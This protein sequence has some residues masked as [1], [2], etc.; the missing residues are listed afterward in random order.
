M[1]RE[2]SLELK[3]T[4]LW[5]HLCYGKSFKFISK[6]YGVSEQRMASITEAVKKALED[7]ERNATRLR[8]T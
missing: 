3:I 6:L 1:D 7:E 5:T 2:P 8:S 4:M